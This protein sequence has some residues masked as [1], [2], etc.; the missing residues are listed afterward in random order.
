MFLP[1][2]AL[3]SNVP[4]P[5]PLRSNVPAFDAPA[6]KGMTFNLSANPGHISEM[7]AY[8]SLSSCS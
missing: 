7:T 5:T 1:L 2:T 3:G 4:V 8:S 6:M